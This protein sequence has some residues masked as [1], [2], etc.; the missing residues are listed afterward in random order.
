LFHWKF[1][2]YI[3]KGLSFVLQKILNVGGAWGW[4]HRRQS[5]WDGGSAAGRE[6]L[7]QKN[8]TQ[9]VVLVDDRRHGVHRRHRHVSYATILTPVIPEA[10]GHILVASFIHVAPPLRSPASWFRKRE[11]KQL[12][13]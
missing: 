7:S 12:A 9:R 11:R 6:A 10:L 2:S 4:A 1:L 5:F 3:V 13:A 8:D